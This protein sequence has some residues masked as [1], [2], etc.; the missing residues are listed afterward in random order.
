MV[1]LHFSKV[2]ETSTFCNSVEKNIHGHAMFRKVAFLEFSR[3]P[4]LTGAAGLHVCYVMYSLFK[5]DYTFLDS[6][7]YS[8]H[9]T[10]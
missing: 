4:L 7:P 10:N 5:V 6:A 3:S 9:K 1:E 2:R 8:C